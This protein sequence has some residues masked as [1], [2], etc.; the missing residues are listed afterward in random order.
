[1]KLYN[2]NLKWNKTQKAYEFSLEN[3]F[4]YSDGVEIYPEGFFRKI[5]K[6]LTFHIVKSGKGRLKISRKGCSDSV[7]Y[8]TSKE[9]AYQD[10][11]K[12]AQTKGR[13]ILTIEQSDEI[14][15]KRELKELNG[16]EK[17]LLLQLESLRARKE[18][19]AD[20]YVEQIPDNVKILDK[21]EVKR[22]LIKEK[23]R[24]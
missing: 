3:P 4:R 15:K 1:M 19:L 20:G 18:Q 7:W 2:Y 10:A 11:V 14:L 5:N 22:E 23:L 12:E 24:G 6:Y 21:E 17:G 8:Y 13:P 16:N 9:R